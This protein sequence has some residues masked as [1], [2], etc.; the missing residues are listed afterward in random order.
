MTILKE[1]K[2]SKILSLKLEKGRF[3]GERNEIDYGEER[4]STRIY[5][6]NKPFA[7]CAYLLIVNPQ[8]DE[9]F[10][11][12]ESIDDAKKLLDDHL[13]YDANPAKFNISPKQE[14]WAH[15]SNLQAWYENDYD[16]RLLDSKL[17]F[18]LLQKL[19]KVG[20]S[21]AKKR[22]A[23]ELLERYAKGNKDIKYMLLH[24]D[25]FD[26]IPF[27][28]QISIIED[29]DDYNVMVLLN[30]VLKG[31]FQ[32]GD[33]K[34]DNGKVTTLFLKNH[35]YLDFIPKEIGNL[36]NL[37]ILHISLSN[38]TS[39]PDSIG[40]LK[41]LKKLIINA[42]KLTSMPDSAGN[43]G[44]LEELIIKKAELV[45]LPESVGNLGNLRMLGIERCE[46]FEK[47]PNSLGNL[48]K[49]ESLW[50]WD[51]HLKKLPESIGGLES[52]DSLEIEHSKLQ[53]LPE[54]IGNLKHPKLGF[55]ITDGMVRTLPESIGNMEAYSLVVAKHQ[56]EKLPESIGN[57]KN[58]KTLN[59]A[60][61]KIKKLPESIENLKTL[62]NLYL[63][64]NELKDLPKSF[65]SLKSLKT[66][67]LDANKLDKIPKVIFELSNLE[68][69]SLGANQITTIPEEIYK[70][71]KLENL[72]LEELDI[73]KLPVYFRHKKKNKRPILH[74]D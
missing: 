33:F 58:L 18:P 45:S 36:K 16:T 21:K 31:E 62:E 10:E 68:S 1:F 51:S 49:L 6:N 50:I 46:R 17:A 3:D 19:M 52:L 65:K 72:Y 64:G 71:R 7:I 32:L 4:F 25:Y 38:L 30:D 70:L 43:L 53:E 23:E 59:L 47:L 74:F 54:S 28:E 56:I 66:L 15:C 35:P 5:V 60:G 55:I 12:I 44:L 24:S 22:Y 26:D 37:Q 73:I 11:E 61:N 63:N 67:I 41:S 2:I 39:L 42:P 57:I 20:D 29:P 8:N 69:L 40:S 9:R 27:E 14:F 13:E 34:V 48:R